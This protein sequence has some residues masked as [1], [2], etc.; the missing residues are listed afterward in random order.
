MRVLIVG[1]LGGQLSAATKIAM[2]RGAKVAHVDTIAQATAYLRAGK[3]ADLLMVDVNL[4]VG[5]L[6]AAN[7]AE[8]II[9]PVIA[10]GV[11]VRPEAAAGA[12]KAGAKE[13]I[14][15][16]PEPELIAAVLEAVSDDDRTLI[17][18]DPAM[19]D[20]VR[21]AEQ[22]GP[23]DASVLITGESGVGKEVMARYVHK[24]SKRASKAFVS[25]NCA[26]IPENLLESELFGHEKGAFTGALARRIGKFEE[27]DGGTLLLDEISEMDVRLQAKLL[28]ALQEREIDRVG[29]SKPVKVNIRVLATSNRDLREAVKDGTFREDLLFRLNVVNLAIPPLRDRPE[30]TLAL[31]DHFLKK[32]AKANGVDYRPL[33]EASK[34]QVVARAWKGNVRELENAMHRAVLLASGD[35]IEPEAIRLPDGS[36]L[37]ASSAGAAMARQAAQAADEAINLVGKTVAEVEKDLILDTLDH[38]LGNRTHA[39]NILG[40]SIRTLRNKLKLYGEQGEDIPGPGESRFAG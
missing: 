30:D 38:C 5:S 8:R 22:I 29:G 13:F 31:A 6:I 17:A 11:N 19:L 39:A 2:D 36:P 26:A 20:V 15:L 35:K 28:R 34:A 24:K 18:R 27:A 4:D 21:L 25:V 16:P 12:I 33:S 14:H 40:I 37:P 23:S 32:Y 10:C 9:V 1:S 3:G 7:E